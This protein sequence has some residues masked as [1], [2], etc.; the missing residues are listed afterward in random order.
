MTTW[1][2]TSTSSSRPAAIAS[3]VRWRSSG[4]RRRVARSGGC[5]PGPR[6]IASSRTASRNSSPT[7][8][9]DADTLPTYTLETRWTTFFALRLRTR[10]SSRSR[11]PIS[12]Q[13]PVRHVPRRAD[14]PAPGRPVRHRPPAELERRRE[15]RRLRRADPRDPGELRVRGPRERPDARVPR[16]RLLGQLERAPSRRRP[17][18]RP[19]AISSAAESPPG[20]RRASRSRGRSA[21]GR[22]RTERD[23]R[24]CAGASSTRPLPIVM[25]HLPSGRRAAVYAPA[26]RGVPGARTT[27]ARRFPPPSGPGNTTKATRAPLTGGSRA[28]WPRLW[29]PGR[30]RPGSPSA[31]SRTATASAAAAPGSR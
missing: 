14:R 10:S 5:G 26:C 8:T 27:E 2:S 30:R 24:R 4:R 25:T 17:C 31:A 9:S 12:T 7:R 29:A 19:R 1:S 3:A 13:Q 11:R 6:P 22:S 20:P 16:Q 21:A 28:A 23:A 18:P 15:P